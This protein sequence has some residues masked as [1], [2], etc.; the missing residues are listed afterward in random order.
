MNGAIR[1]RDLSRT[2]YQTFVSGCYVNNI[3]CIICDQ[4]ISCYCCGSIIAANDYIRVISTGS[5]LTHIANLHG[6]CFDANALRFTTISKWLLLARLWSLHAIPLI[7]DTRNIIVALLI[8]S[9]DTLCVY[10]FMASRE[11]KLTF[12]AWLPHDEPSILAPNQLYS[13]IVFPS[14]G[15][16]VILQQTVMYYLHRDDPGPT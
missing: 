12:F 5:S 1:F 10:R 11:C 4:A 2:I 15:S 9:P 3:S 8:A 14:I 7:P 16:P 6:N 13:H